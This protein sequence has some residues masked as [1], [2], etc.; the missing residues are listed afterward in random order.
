MTS[1]ITPIRLR[2]FNQRI[3]SALCNNNLLN[4]WVIADLSDVGVKGG[5][6]YLD[7]VDKDPNSG[8]IYAKIRGII[9]AN[10]FQALKC[11]FETIT[12]QPFQSG[13]KVMIQVSVNYHAVFGLSLIVSDLNP[14]FTLGDMERQRREILA[15]LAKEGIINM[16]KELA[17]PLVPQRIAIISAQGA[18]GYGDFINQLHSNPNK[19]QFYTA[20]FEARMQGTETS[21]S[22]I[23]ALEAIKKNAHKFD[24]VVI[25]RGG[26]ASS[27]LNSFDDYNLAAHVAQFPLPI[28]TGIGHERDN[29]VID[30]VSNLRIKTPTAVAEWLIEQGENVLS[31][32]NQLSQ[33]VVSSAREYIKGSTEQLRY[34]NSTIPILAKS[35]VE[36]RSSQLREFGISI[37]SMAETRI[38][39]AKNNLAHYQEYIKQSIN[40]RIKIENMKLDRLNDNVNMLS[41][42][43]TLKR[44]YSITTINGKAVTQLKSVNLEDEICTHLADGVI[45]SNVK[46]KYTK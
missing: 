3:A 2:D 41:P 16:N 43:N 13:I 9:W 31:R 23:A 22:I 35:I 7:L 42:V 40:Q 30:Y 36:K 32:L 27:D 18:A 4:C 28:I 33:T 20:L 14:D 6:C 26:G 25:I 8:T 11:N 21:P 37:P 46:S 10:K 39:T 5:H 24:V 34:Y 15:R 1:D 44:G 29:T 17:M 45:I 19:I 12:G 38:A